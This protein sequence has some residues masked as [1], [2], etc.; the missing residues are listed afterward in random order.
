VREIIRGR[1]R[2][3]KT[4]SCFSA[5]PPGPFLYWFREKER[6]APRFSTVIEAI[7]PRCRRV[8]VTRRAWRRAMRRRYRVFPSK[9]QMLADDVVRCRRILRGKTRPAVVRL[10]G[11]PHSREPRS[12]L[13]EI[14]PERDSFF[15]VDSEILE[16]RFDRRGV[17]RRASFFQG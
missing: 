13:Y 1:C 6:F 15:Q 16:I 17:F 5:W 2:E 7:R 3:G 8:T 12:I 9:L 11:K 4:W 10:L 14:G